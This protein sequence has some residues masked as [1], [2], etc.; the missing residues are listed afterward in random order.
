MSRRRVLTALRFLGYAAVLAFLGW[1]LWRVRAGLAD[2]LRAVGWCNALAAGALAAVGGVPSF[3]GWRVLL[4]GLGTRLSLRAAAWV[5]FL[6]GVTRY[7]PG[8]VWPTVAHAAMARPLGEPPAR[9]AGAF[10]TSQGLGVVSGLFVGLLALPR[11]VAADPWW[12]LLLPVLVAASVPLIAPRL[13]GTLL[14]TGAKLL[15]RGGGRAAGPGVPD[16]PTLLRATGLMLVGW[17]IS[18]LHVAV[19][20]V[21]L[22]AEPGAAVL[23]GTGGFALAVV[24]GIFAVVMPTG[25]GVREVALALTLASLLSGSDLVT[26]VALSRVLLTVG[27]VG[28]TAAVLAGL[29]LTGRAGAVPPGSAGP[30]PDPPGSAGPEPDPVSARLEGVSP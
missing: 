24:A 22:G 13:L 26:L 9:L 29:A 30:E 23:V 2:S 18:G 8:G 21:A 14:T 12:W 7:L 11:L 3:F 4:A 6:G 20:A 19:L 5:F 25:F 17:L 15:R 27:D 16:R 10:L 28:S 1:Q